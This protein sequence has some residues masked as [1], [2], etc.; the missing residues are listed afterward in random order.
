MSNTVINTLYQ[1]SHL[2]SVTVIKKIHFDVKH[3]CVWIS[4][5]PLLTWPWASYVT[6]LSLSLAHRKHSVNAYCYPPNEMHININTFILQTRNLRLRRLRNC[7]G[8]QNLRIGPRL[9]KQLQD[10]YSCRLCLG[11]ELRNGGAQP[12]PP[13]VYWWQPRDLRVASAKQTIVFQKLEVNGCQRILAAP[14]Q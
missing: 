14:A 6:S 5:S 2:I 7:A 10:L 3:I 9:S 4:P 12:H 13:I 8:S 1:L 11:T